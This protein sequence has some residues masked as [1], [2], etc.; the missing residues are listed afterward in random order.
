MTV[1][2]QVKDNSI[3]MYQMSLII[4][5][6]SE[7][8]KLQDLKLLCFRDKHT[9]VDKMAELLGWLLFGLNHMSRKVIKVGIEAR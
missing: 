6:N 7:S 2:I 4:R 9:A 5:L 3:V 1:V 8:I